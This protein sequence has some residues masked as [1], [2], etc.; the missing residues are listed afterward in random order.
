MGEAHN[1]GYSA[2]QRGTTSGLLDYTGFPKASY[3]MMKSL[4]HDEATL[5]ITTQTVDKSLYKLE[6]NKLVERKKDGWQQALWVW[7]NVNTH[8]NYKEDENIVVEIISNLPELELFLNGKSLGVKKMA[9]FDD[10]LYK[11]LVPYTKGE[12]LAK[13]T[14]KGKEISSKIIT[15][16]KPATI[17]IESDKTTLTA[18]GYDVAHIVV[19]IMDDNGNPVL[20][21]NEEIEFEISGEVKLLGVDN[22]AANSLQ[23]YQS[24]KITTYKGRALLLIQA[25][26]TAC[27]VFIHA[28]GENIE[29]ETI[30]LTVK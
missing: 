14:S 26:Q 1:R 19:Q 15:E 5:H 11:W 25:K 3:Y 12:L 27:D 16:G 24:N 18:D 21:E 22:G 2:P 9:D 4:W 7:Q 23:T 28:R 30:S 13:G 8:W 29:S 6:N 17:S 20:L 10:R